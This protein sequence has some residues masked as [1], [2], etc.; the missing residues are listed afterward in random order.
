MAGESDAFDDAWAG[1]HQK[2]VEALRELGGRKDVPFLVAQETLWLLDGYILTVS[3]LPDT[4]PQTEQYL[5]YTYIEEPELLPAKMLEL[6]KALKEHA[7]GWS[8]VRVGSKAVAQ[9]LI[10]FSDSIQ[11]QGTEVMGYAG[12]TSA[13]GPN[14]EKWELSGSPAAIEV[15]DKAILLKMASSFEALRAPVEHFKA[16]LEHVYS[17]LA[18]F[19]DEARFKLRPAVQEKIRALDRLVRAYKSEQKLAEDPGSII[20]G[21][22]AAGI[23]GAQ[24]K[25]TLHKWE[26]S[27]SINISGTASIHS[28]WQ[29]MDAY[30]EQSEQRLVSMQTQ[31]ELADFMIRYKIFLAQ[32]AGIKT[33]AQEQLSAFD[34]TQQA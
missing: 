17:D 10:V 20:Y 14:A 24:L 8:R 25:V 1:K 29:G 22:V 28:A 23:S 7:G 12:K 4:V 13:L 19:R 18:T 30:L 11:T 15:Q 16:S 6:F 32:W 33:F 5:A 27:L 2:I 9:D 3:M 21:S 31:E 34:S 26:A